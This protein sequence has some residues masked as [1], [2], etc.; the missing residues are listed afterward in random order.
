[1]W[2][3]YLFGLVSE[4]VSCADAYFTWFAECDDRTAERISGAR[5]FITCVGLV[6]DI[7]IHF[8]CVNFIS[9]FQ[10]YNAIAIFF[11]LVDGIEIH[12]PVVN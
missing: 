7:G 11:H 9:N 10:V 1:M 5:C 4:A 2:N 3:N 6:I 8:A 12:I